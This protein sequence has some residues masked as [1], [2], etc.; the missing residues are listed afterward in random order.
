MLLR[1]IFNYNG[2]KKMMGDAPTE[3]N[4]SSVA[5]H[6]GSSAN[7]WT[8]PEHVHQLLMCQPIV[9]PTPWSRII[10]SV[11]A[12]MIVVIIVNII[13]IIVNIMTMIVVP[14]AVTMIGW[15]G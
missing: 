9:V 10:I 7:H 11:T 2:L 13:V 3:Q 14:V 15:T 12:G 8:I 4:H 1:A 6:L 5:A